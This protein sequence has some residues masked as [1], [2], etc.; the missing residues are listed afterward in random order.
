MPKSKRFA[1]SPKTRGKIVDPWAN[2]NGLIYFNRAFDKSR[3]KGLVKWTLDQF[4]EK[5]TLDVVETL[6]GVGYCSAT[7]AGLS[8]SIDDLLVPPS[9]ISHIIQTETQLEHTQRRVSKGYLTS[10]EYL[11]QV[12]TTW[13]VTNDVIKN[14]VIA[15]FRSKDILNPVYMMAFSGARGNISQVRQLTGMRGLMSDPSGN[16]I[17]YA[18][19]SNFREGLTLTEYVISCYGA[20]KGVVDTALRTATSGYLTRRLVDVAQHVVIRRYDCSTT[21]GIYLTALENEDKVFMTGPFRLAGR[22]LAEDVY[23]TNLNRPTRLAQR[24]QEVTPKL[25]NQLFK[26]HKKILVRSPLTCEDKNFVCQLCYGWNLSSGRLVSIGET[27]GIIAAQSIGEPGTQLTMRTF[28]TGGVFSGEISKTL[29]APVHGKVS[30]LNTIPGKCVRTD[31][32][33]VAFLT[34]QSGTLYITHLNNPEKKRVTKYFLQPYTLVFVKQ[35]EIVYPNQTLAELSS[36]DSLSNKQ[37]SYQTIF[38]PLAGEV[39]FKNTSVAKGAHYPQHTTFVPLNQHASEFWVLSAQ[40]QKFMNPIKAFVKPGDRVGLKSPVLTYILF[41]QPKYDQFDSFPFQQYVCFYRIQTLFT[42]LQQKIHNL[43]TTLVFNPSHDENRLKPA[44]W[45]SPAFMERGTI[46]ER[47][48]PFVAFVPK[49]RLWFDLKQMVKKLQRSRLPL[50]NKTIQSARKKTLQ[51]KAKKQGLLLQQKRFK[52][53]NMKHFFT[54]HRFSTIDSNVCKQPDQSVYKLAFNKKMLSFL[55]CPRFPFTHKHTPIFSPFK[56]ERKTDG[57]LLSVFYA[58]LTHFEKKLF[59]S[60]SL[61]PGMQDKFRFMQFNERFCLKPL[62]NYYSNPELHFPISLSHCPTK[63]LWSIAYLNQPTECFK[64]SF[65][66]ML[67]Q[68]FTWN[69]SCELERVADL[70]FQHF[71]PD[72]C[73]CFRFV[74]HYRFQPL[75]EVFLYKAFDFEPTFE[76][77]SFEQLFETASGSFLVNELNGEFV[78]ETIHLPYFFVKNPPVFDRVQKAIYDKACLILFKQKYEQLKQPLSQRKRKNKNN[79]N[80]NQNQNQWERTTPYFGNFQYKNQ[81]LNDQVKQP[82]FLKPNNR[83]YVTPTTVYDYNKICNF[84]EFIQLPFCFDLFSVKKFKQLRSLVGNSPQKG[85]GKTVDLS[86]TSLTQGLLIY[87]NMLSHFQ[88]Q[89]GHTLSI[90]QLR[91]GFLNSILQKTLLVQLL[92]NKIEGTWETSNKF[93]SFIPLLISSFSKLL[94]WKHIFQ[95]LNQLA[96]FSKLKKMLAVQKSAQNQPV[97]AVCYFV[98]KACYKNMFVRNIQQLSIWQKSFF[99]QVSKRVWFSIKKRRQ[100]MMTRLNLVYGLTRIFNSFTIDYFSFFIRPI[101]SKHQSKSFRLFLPFLDF[102]LCCFKT[103]YHCGWN[104]VSKNE[105]QTQYGQNY[106]YTGWLLQLLQLLYLKQKFKPRK[107]K[108]KFTYRLKGVRSRIRSKM[109]SW[110][111]PSRKPQRWKFPIH[112][113]LFPFVSYKATQVFWQKSRVA[114]IE[115]FLQKNYQDRF[116]AQF[117]KDWPRSRDLTL[118]FL[119]TKIVNSM[120][121]TQTQFKGTSFMFNETKIENGL[122]QQ[123]PFNLEKLKSPHKIVY[124]LKQIK[125]DFLTK[126]KCHKPKQKQ[127]KKMNQKATSLIKKTSFPLI[128]PFKRNPSKVL[129]SFFVA[130]FLQ[131][132]SKQKRFT[133]QAQYLNPLSWLSLVSFADKQNQHFQP[134]FQYKQLKMESTRHTAFAFSHTKFNSTYDPWWRHQAHSNHV[135]TTLVGFEKQSQLQ[136]TALLMLIRQFKKHPNRFFA[137]YLE[138]NFFNQ[139]LFKEK[140]TLKTIFIQDLSFYV[141]A[142]KLNVKKTK[143]SP[144]QTNSFEVNLKALNHYVRFV[145]LKTAKLPFI[146]AAKNAS[147]TRLQ[148]RFLLIQQNLIYISKM[149][150][151]RPSLVFS[152]VKYKEARNI[153]LIAKPSYILSMQQ[154]V[155]VYRAGDSLCKTFGQ[156][157]FSSLDQGSFS[158]VMFLASPKANDQKMSIPAFKLVP[159]FNSSKVNKFQSKLLQ[160]SFHPSA[161][162]TMIYQNQKFATHTYVS[163]QLNS[164]KL[165][166][167]FLC[168]F[169]QGRANLQD[170]IRY[171]KNNTKLNLTQTIVQVPISV[172]NSISKTQASTMVT[173]TSHVSGFVLQCVD[174]QT[175]SENPTVYEHNMRRFRDQPTAEYH[176]SYLTSRDVVTYKLMSALQKHKLSSF[177]AYGEKVNG[178]LLNE[179]GQIIYLTKKAF[180]LRKAQ[181]FFLAAGSECNLHQG[182]IV[183]FGS[184]LVKVAYSQIQT[185]DIIQGIPKINQLFEARTRFGFQNLKELL[186][187]QYQFLK[188]EGRLT[189]RAILLECI[190]FIQKQIV[191]GVQNVYQS[192]GVTISDKHIEIIVKQM[193]SKVRVNTAIRTGFLRGDVIPFHLVESLNL[194]AEDLLFECEPILLGITQA[195]LQAEGFL[196]AASFQ[197]TVR[198]L[199]QAVVVRKIDYLKNLKENIIIGH[200]LP[201]GTGFLERSFKTIKD[202]EKPLINQ[203]FSVK[204]LLKE[205]ANEQN[206]LTDL[207]EGDYYE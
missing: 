23:D 166:F 107:T 16:I 14:Q 8:L 11:S 2:L 205:R 147:G 156:S 146:F 53:N 38:S 138:K 48:L 75:A 200:L 15:H 180:V 165:S 17:D 133:N 191:D 47:L 174:S 187:N 176:I 122:V 134:S 207:N 7:E 42:V 5:K 91:K 139:T 68:G 24:N 78:H 127:A 170:R 148:K 103:K 86:K 45:I 9:K 111:Y 153:E 3:L 184:P 173:K 43:S 31:Q 33:E 125:K 95:K 29:Q 70:N 115:P 79:Q 189:K 77:F 161:R 94:L 123:K 27:V 106:Y 40:T 167:N 73:F 72:L 202:Q 35:G 117:Q 81:Q 19:Q 76:P 49:Q 104:T 80:Q 132:T 154:K 190:D 149:T 13:N 140:S 198:V 6:K 21:K 143:Q 121:L 97:N 39:K 162:W 183:S 203:L 55:P 172:K 175:E 89:T 109:R 63:N 92:K 59:L 74:N 201:T 98:K 88:M 160:S 51:Q 181:C 64:Q 185:E 112:A 65:N 155:A 28:H 50:K 204:Y 142:M 129:N 158:N 159:S 20:R 69:L 144:N 169:I 99:S 150:R 66:D 137:S 131:I 37:L 179:P 1:R 194:D 34:K 119:L 25:A 44:A 54:F 10:V 108:R 87:S 151:Y 195:A 52:K 67:P 196:S 178:S 46:L 110:F 57:D 12:I 124:F 126:Q 206:Q 128:Q 177:I 145:F 56:F 136:T 135:S 113:S 84:H 71:F 188:K 22:V 85:F 58:W 61:P 4:G 114:H 182:D 141:Q 26:Y 93:L 186:A 36:L 171:A 100:L 18:I 157:D 118:Q 41:A 116:V 30:F 32:G 102:Y 130:P 163:H 90:V 120:D 62:E 192:Q 152:S 168:A 197:E 199:S 101:L 83:Q 193:T 105:N 82:W 96:T 164:S 60:I